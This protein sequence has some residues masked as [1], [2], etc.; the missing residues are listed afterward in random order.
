MEENTRNLSPSSPA[1]IGAQYGA[2]AGLASIFYSLAAMT[3]GVDQNTIV[4]I[5]GTAVPVIF[6]VLG[7]LTYRRQND[8]LASFG[9]AY[10]VCFMVAS[11]T[12]VIASIFTYAYF[13]LINPEFYE[14][15]IEQAVLRM[16][17]KGTPDEAIET[18]KR[19]MTPGYSAV[20]GFLGNIFI[21]GIIGLLVAAILKRSE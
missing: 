17:E 20:F 7:V 19:F 9:Q 6:M 12:A 5:I 11:L 14:A 10:L 21:L 1:I 2:Y 4:E 8:G 13:S 18:A 15:T 3:L 16:E